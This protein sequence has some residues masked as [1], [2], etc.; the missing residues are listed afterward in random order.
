M[1]YTK[2]RPEYCD[3]LIKYFNKKAYEYVLDD[4]NNRVYGRT[5]AIIDPCEFPTMEGFASSIGV[6]TK[7]LNEWAISKDEF[8][9]AKEIAQQFQRDILF[10]NAMTGGYNSQ[11]AQFFCRAALNMRDG[12]ESD[13]G[14]EPITITYVVEDARIRAN[15]EHEKDESGNAEA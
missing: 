13:Q 8:A 3:L 4:D 9:E 7:T 15:V 11:F 1:A 5:G 6:S 14:A 10:K 2:Y 12:S